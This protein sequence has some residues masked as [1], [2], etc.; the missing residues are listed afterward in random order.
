MDSAS[1]TRARKSDV[2]FLPSATLWALSPF[3]LMEN[4]F[5]ELLCIDPVNFYQTV[6]CDTTLT[7]FF[8][9]CQPCERRNSIASRAI[10]YRAAMEDRRSR[11]KVGGCISANDSNSGTGIVRGTYERRN[12]RNSKEERTMHG[13]QGRRRETKRG[14]ERMVLLPTVEG[15]RR[16]REGG[17]G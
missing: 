1:D 11:G 10:E 8:G 3:P 13:G 4:L 12:A 16:G 14:G 7:V 5:S 6:P 9:S 15:K 17:R 2:S